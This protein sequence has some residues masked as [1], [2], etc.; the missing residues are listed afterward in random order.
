LDAQEELVW[1][2]ESRSKAQR[3]LLDTYT[4]L[5]DKREWLQQRPAERSVFGLLVGAGF[6]LWRAA[7]LVTRTTSE[8]PDVLDQA[9]S[10][11]KRLVEDNWISFDREDRA[12]DWTSGYYLNSA[13][14]R[15]HRVR[16]K[17][18]EIAPGETQRSA[19]FRRFEEVEAAGGVDEKDRIA[20]WDK[21]HDALRAALEMVRSRAGG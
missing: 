3:L 9:E 19:A 7:F 14:Y 16:E 1:L 12:R 13:R 20:A 10:F 6:S 11:L 8:W 21:T 17:L 2:V 15:L 5:R 18:D 4:F